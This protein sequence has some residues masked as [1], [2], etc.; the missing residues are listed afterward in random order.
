V[1]STDLKEKTRKFTEQIF[2][3]S[4]S[5]IKEAAAANVV[6]SNNQ[7]ANVPLKSSYEGHDGM[8]A[9]VAD[10]KEYI[11]LGPIGY[12]RIFQDGTTVIGF[13]V[14]NSVVRSTGKAYVMPFV[15]VYHY[16]DGGKIAKLRIF[17]NTHRLATAFE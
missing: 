17:N 5:A 12:D 14:E 2:S 4:A 11:D 9:Y 6:V 10:L 7:P 16:D 1:S 8:A 15:H 13:G 3:D